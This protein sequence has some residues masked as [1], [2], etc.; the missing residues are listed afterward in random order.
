MK[1]MIKTALMSFAAIAVLPLTLIYL[2]MRWGMG[3][4]AGHF[5]AFSQLL[6]LLPGRLG[7]YFRYGFYR[8]TLAYCHPH[9]FIGFGALLSQ[10]DIDL[11]EGVYIGPQCNIGCCSIGKNTLLG[12]A[13]HIMSGKGQH[14]F[15]DLSTPIKDQGG[16]LIKVSIGEDC[17]VGNGALIMA[18]IGKY[19]IVGAGSVVTEPVPDYSIVVGNPARVV[20][21]RK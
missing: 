10:A 5:P 15:D 16:E 20:K 4:R 8:F 3:G 2:L 1:Q 19:C 6:S 7:S 11:A 12:S 13:V 17:W 14:Q 18:D 9:G 21:K